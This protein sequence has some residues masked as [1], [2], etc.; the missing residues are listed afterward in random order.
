MLDSKKD[1]WAF[2]KMGP[3]KV[4]S[5]LYKLI[6]HIYYIFVSFL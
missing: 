1:T 4:L 3:K 6:W 5:A 2:K